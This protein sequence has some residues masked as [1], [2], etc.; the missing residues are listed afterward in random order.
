VKFLVRAFSGL[1]LTLLTLALIGVGIRRFQSAVPDRTANRTKPVQERTYNV[2]VATLEITSL[3]PV[4]TAFG[5]VSAARMLEIRASDAGPIVEISP[6]FRNGATV[7]KDELLFQVD[8]TDFSQ[9]VMDAKVA[10]TQ[11]RADSKEARDT[12]PLSQEEVKNAR[13]QVNLRRA[14]LKRKSGLKGQG[15]VAQGSLSLTLC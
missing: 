9:R 7:S 4:I 5:Q 1:F 3:A 15:F 14:D 13:R 10:L 12:L 8:P 6:N 11:S 2:D